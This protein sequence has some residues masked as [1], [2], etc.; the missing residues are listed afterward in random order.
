MRF[1][2]LGDF[3]ILSGQ[4]DVYCSPFETYI[5]VESVIKIL[6]VSPAR[7]CCDTWKYE[8]RKIKKNKKEWK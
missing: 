3:F 8:K 1:D 7:K 6:I 5:L 2:I 4:R